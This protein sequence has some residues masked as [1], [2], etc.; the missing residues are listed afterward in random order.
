MA[1]ITADT[2]T[3]RAGDTTLKGYLAVDEAKQGKRPAVLVVHEWWGLNDYIRGRAQKLA[4]LGYTAFAVDMYGDGKTGA[5]PGEAGALMTAALSD[6]VALEA[7]FKAAVDLVSSQATVDAS[8]IGA[9]GYCF[10]GAVVLHAARIG[11]PLRGVVSFHGSLGSFHAPAPGSVKAK[12]LVCHGGADALVPDEQI[13]AFKQEMDAAKADYRF[14]VY[15]G[16]LHGYTNPEATEK[17]KTY[18]MP[19]AY[20]AEADRKSWDDMKRF[21]AEVFA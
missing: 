3:Y 21:F 5:D 4:E 13:A 15:D 12:V 20:Q 7:R 11:L 2:V 17:G 18:G 14:V 10:G 6:R 9:I 19:L 1:N 8:R 16:A